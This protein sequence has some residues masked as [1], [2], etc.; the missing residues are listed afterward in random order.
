MENNGYV[1][2]DRQ[3]KVGIIT[4]YHPKS[5][6][7][8]SDILASL[9]ET[10]ENAGQNPEINTI[11]LQSKGEKS[12]CSGASF[13]ELIQ[14][15]DLA[16][17]RKFFMGFAKVI[18]AMR[19][20]PKFI[21]TRVQ[22]KAVGGGVGLIAASDYV[23]AHK[24][25]SVKLSEYALGI[26]PNVV[27]PAVERKI[28]AAAFSQMSMDFEWYNADWAQNRG[29]YAHIYNSI[30]E[31]DNAVEKLAKKLS[32]ASPDAARELKKIFWEGTDNWDTL[33]ESRAEISG[34]LVLSDFT[35]NYIRQFKEK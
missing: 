3:E 10:I 11:V 5:N 24:D 8:P 32:E 27:G 31:L 21:I 9:A 23:L 13:D 19:K 1:S 33:L 6:S 35:K 18:N 15:E 29:L 25:S 34:K 30:E 20:A 16:A 12:F 4:F 14:L 22:G 17:S 7:L 28:G 2:F 26:G